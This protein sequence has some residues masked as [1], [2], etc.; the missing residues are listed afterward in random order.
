[1]N[2]ETYEFNWEKYLEEFPIVA[3]VESARILEEDEK[4]MFLF[5][6]G[7]FK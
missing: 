6:F 7:L 2:N 3:D 5:V 1:M 4:D